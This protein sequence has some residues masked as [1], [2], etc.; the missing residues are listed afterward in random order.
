MDRRGVMH[1][2]SISVVFFLVDGTDSAF[3]LVLILLDMVD[4]DVR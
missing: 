3:I 4:F 2:K 1:I